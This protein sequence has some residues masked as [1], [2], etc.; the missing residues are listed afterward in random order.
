MMANKMKCTDSPDELIAAFQVFDTEK[1]GYISV[2]EFRSV[3]TT[4]GDR[5]P[6]EE[7]DEMIKE[8]GIGADGMVHYKGN[9]SLS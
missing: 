2:I 9:L 3:M 1:T 8:T 6:D 4:L 5:L 7:V